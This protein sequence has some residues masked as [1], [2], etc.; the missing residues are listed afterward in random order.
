[1]SSLRETKFAKTRLG[2]ARALGTALES[3]S[4]DEVPVKSLCQVAEV[5]EATFFNYFPNKD[6]LLEYLVQLWILEL[7]W[8][9]AS[10]ESAPG[11]AR[12]QTLFSHCART[13]KER[14]GFMKAVVAWLSAGGITA[15]ERAPGSVERAL[16][17][18]AHPGIEK[19]PLLS[20]DRLLAGQIERA[21]KQNELPDNLPVPMVM[22]GLLA[23]LFGVPLTLLSHDPGRIGSF[24][25][26]QLHIFW[27]GLRAAAGA[28]RSRAAPENQQPTFQPVGRDQADLPQDQS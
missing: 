23:L 25:Q 5:S 12:V 4:I 3:A 2:L 1:M 19:A 21:L 14:P 6:A 11:L 8:T 9:L 22:G 26:Q 16:A 15:A 18:P 7:N 13:C 24:Y 17:Y 28:T 10:A 20:I 27:A